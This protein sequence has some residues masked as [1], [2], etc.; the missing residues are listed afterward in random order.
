MSQKLSAEERDDGL[1]ELSMENYNLF[2]EKYKEYALTCGSAGNIIITGID[3]VMRT[4]RRN[5]RAMHM[6]QD[7]NN[8]GQQI[9][10]EDPAGAFI[11][12]NTARGD[13]QFERYE[14]KY[15]E[16]MNGKKK[17][18]FKLLSK[19]DTTVKSC[20]IFMCQTSRPVYRYNGR[21]VRHIKIQQ[22]GMSDYM[23]TV[24]MIGS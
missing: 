1:P 8:P 10:V 20:W 3:E 5:M 23:M 14:K 7:P 6:I 4:P 2:R 9:E 18:M 19:A 17:L 24:N 22:I 11:F 16:L 15:D 13:S 12:D 21:L